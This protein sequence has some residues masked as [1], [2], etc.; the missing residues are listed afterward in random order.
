[1]AANKNLFRSERLTSIRQDWRTPEMLLKKLDAE[2]QFTLDPCIDEIIEGRFLNWDNERVFINPPY[3]N[4]QSWVEK[5]LNSKNAILVYLL[6]VRTSVGY[7]HDVI[8]PF[9]DEIRFIKG[10]LKFDNQKS[11]APFDSYIVIFKTN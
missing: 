7:F 11:N 9:A 1:M 8:L 10:R 2:F 6:P 4:I 5:G 3:N